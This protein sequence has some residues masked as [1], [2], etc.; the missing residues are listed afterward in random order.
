[1]FFIMA[2]AWR[3]ISGVMPAIMGLKALAYA[4]AALIW[5]SDIPLI[6]SA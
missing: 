4:V 3:I 2:D 6:M 5:S 1:M